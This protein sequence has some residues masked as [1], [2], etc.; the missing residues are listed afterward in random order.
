MK[1]QVNSPRAAATGAA[2]ATA[3]LLAASAAA[4]VHLGRIDVTVQ[5]ATGAVLP[6]AVWR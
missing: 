6:G 3:L 5:D 4:Q 2:F 1:Q